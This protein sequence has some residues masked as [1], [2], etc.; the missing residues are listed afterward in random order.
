MRPAPGVMQGACPAIPHIAH[1]SHM[2]KQGL[3]QKLLQKLSPQQ[4]QFI[5]LLQIPTTALE[6]RIQEELEENPALMEAG[7]LAEEQPEGPYADE[8]T[9]AEPDYEQ[10]KDLSLDEYVNQQEDYAY[11][12][13]QATDPNEER[14]ETPMVQGY[15]M[16]DELRRQL[17]MKV[18]DDHAWMIAEQIIGNIDE[19]GYFRRPIASITDDLAFRYS[20][21]VQDAEVEAVLH[22]VQTLDP[23]GIAA[24]DLQECLSLQ[25]QRRPSSPEVVLARSIV[26]TYFDEFTKKHLDKIQER[27]GAGSALFKEAYTLIT[28]LNPKPG[29][30]AAVGISQIITPDY[31]VRVVDGEVDVKLNQKNAPELRVNRRYIRM[32]GDMDRADKKK[33][34][35]AD[36]ET[37]SF[38]KQKIEAAHWFI[39]AIQQRQLTLLRTMVAIIDKQREFFVNEDDEGCLRPMILKDIADEI[40]M[41]ISTVSRVASSK[42]VQTEYGIY[43]LKFFFS[44]GVTT[45]SGDEVSTREIKKVLQALIDE[46]DRL[47]PLSDDRL[48]E[49]LAEKGYDIARRT[50]AKYREQLNIPVARLRKSL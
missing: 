47:K 17:S 22:L 24:R 23:P 50:V 44:E 3:H 35:T 10:N 16:Y 2:L 45:Q 28:R 29:G 49:M 20:Y 32:L 11:K 40:G 4:I 18:L 25:L 46:E 19:D 5:K 26:D 31:I 37:L 41:D 15:S 43:P 13:R 7:T 36:K 48:T 1:F 34:S 30:T 8:P 27:T 9:E 39:E 42:Y 38:V 12:T 6:A 21:T 14:Y 33:M